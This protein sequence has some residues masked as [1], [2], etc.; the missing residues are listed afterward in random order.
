MEGMICHGLRGLQEIYTTVK[1]SN[2]AGEQWATGVI[3]KLLETTHR[4][5][6]YHCIQVYNMISG[7]QA[8]QQKE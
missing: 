6:L 5:W 1:G 3:I 7:I 8:T 4:Q 2:I